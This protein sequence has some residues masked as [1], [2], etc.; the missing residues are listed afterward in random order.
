M[1]RMLSVRPYAR[2]AQALH[3]LPP[4]G[5][6]RRGAPCAAC[7]A[8]A[9]PCASGAAP[10]PH[11]LRARCTPHETRAPYAACATPEATS[12]ATPKTRTSFAI[13]CGTLTTSPARSSL[14][15]YTDPYCATLR[16]ISWCRT[17][18][19]KDYSVTTALLFSG[20]RSIWQYI[21][22]LPNI[23]S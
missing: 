8:A 12:A 3:W 10:A 4:W 17:P 7:R 13:R 1:A 6:R 18:T 14:H 9:W 2:S 22:H 19:T 11:L 21:I 5:R 16:S 15:T 20:C 23:R